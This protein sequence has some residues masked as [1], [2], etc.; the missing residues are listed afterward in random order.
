MTASETEQGR[1][2]AESRI[3][4]L[5]GGEKVEARFMRQDFF[6]FQPQLKLLICGNHKPG[7]NAVDEAIRR[8]FH[9]IPFTVTIPT[10]ERDETLPERLKTEWPGVLAWMVEGCLAW[11]RGG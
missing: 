3:K 11:Q 1:K 8:R 4:M 6:E 2:W 7:L 9:L 5:T 10:D